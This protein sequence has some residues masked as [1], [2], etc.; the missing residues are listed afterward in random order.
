MSYEFV[1]SSYFYIIVLFGLAY[2]LHIKKEPPQVFVL[3]LMILI[4]AKAPIFYSAFM[5]AIVSVSIFWD[6]LNKVIILGFS[7][8]VAVV[9]LS[10]TAIPPPSSGQGFTSYLYLGL[11]EEGARSTLNGVQGWFLSDPVV[12]AIQKYFKSLPPTGV[13]LLISLFILKIYVIGAL[14]IGAIG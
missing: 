10:W 11:T 2:T 5:C 7:I 9:I 12:L 4:C 8:G 6:R 3:L 1:I 13:Y 14:V